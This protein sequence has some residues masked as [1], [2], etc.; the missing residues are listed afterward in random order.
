VDRNPFVPHPAV[1]VHPV[2]WVVGGHSWECM[3][4]RASRV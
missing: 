2:L 3:W 1:E 4:T